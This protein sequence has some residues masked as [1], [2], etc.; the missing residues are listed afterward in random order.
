M[1]RSKEQSRIYMRNRYRAKQAAAGR[2]VREHVRERPP[3]DPIDAPDI[4][5]QVRDSIT[6]QVLGDPPVGRSAL[7]RRQQ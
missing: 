6:A 7:D 3:S 4:A 1:P 2:T 5:S